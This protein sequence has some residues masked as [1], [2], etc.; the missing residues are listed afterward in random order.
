MK[1]AHI[2]NPVKVGRS[3]DLYRAQPITFETMRM[4]A[5]YIQSGLEVKLYSA[6]F[7]RDKKIIPPYFSQTPNLERSVLDMASFR[8][9]R[10]LPL[11][12]DII[13]RLYQASQADY[14]IYTNSDIALQPH[15]YKTVSRLLG[16][17]Y[18]AFVINRRTIPSHYW[19]IGEIPMML[20]LTGVSHK[21]HDCFV[22]PRT[23]VP[24]FILGNLCIGVRQVGRVLLWNLLDQAQQFAEFKDFNLTFHLGD[25]KTWKDSRF[26][27]YDR[28]NTREATGVLTLLDSR[29]NRTFIA[30]L[31][32]DYPD[33][34]KGV[35]LPDSHS[36]ERLT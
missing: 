2:I 29:A 5:G 33:Y 22:F 26:A 34:L 1:I 35:V 20:A 8:K 23:M 14:F 25:N 19:K 3:S 30:R 12:R 7:A 32:K 16:K 9:K 10:K 36:M 21:G 27:D 18:D 31:E 28:F 11:L 17:G 6:Q 15:F 24:G 4:A 13:Q